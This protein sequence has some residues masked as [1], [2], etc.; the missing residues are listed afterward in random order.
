MQRREYLA[1]PLRVRAQ[2]GFLV[3]LRRY[4][5][6]RGYEG[7]GFGRLLLQDL[8]EQAPIMVPVRLDGY[9]H[10]VAFRGRHGIGY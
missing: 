8:I 9:N 6:K 1:D 4:V 2:Q 10:F 3:D 5:D 7:I